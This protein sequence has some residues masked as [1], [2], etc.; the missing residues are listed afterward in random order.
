MAQGPSLGNF[1]DEYPGIRS[2]FTSTVDGAECPAAR[3]TKIFP[4]S[5][6]PKQDRLNP[7]EISNR[8]MFG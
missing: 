1:S 7:V 2:F 4:L 5:T 3:H 6:K 8:E